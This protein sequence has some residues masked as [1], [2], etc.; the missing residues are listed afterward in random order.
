M[1]SDV[2]VTQVDEVKNRIG[3]T[4]QEPPA[5]PWESI[6]RGAVMRGK[7]VKID[8]RGAYVEVGAERPGMIG[9]RGFGVEFGSPEDFVTEGEEVEVTVARVDPVRKILDFNLNGLNKED[10]ALSSG[11]D[12]EFNPMEA[13]MR[14]AQANR[15]I[16]AAPTAAGKA[17]P[18]SQAK[19]QAA[20]ADA[21]ARTL[22][23]LEKQK[24]EAKKQD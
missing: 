15:R 11:P 22:A 9:M 4:M 3:L 14:K 20:Q 12:E 18:P 8:R 23:M 19:K 2:W 21:I 24:Q 7:V 1:L 10:Y 5:M 17:A 6:K 16:A 13:A